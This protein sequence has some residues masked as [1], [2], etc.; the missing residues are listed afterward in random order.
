VKHKEGKQK[1]SPPPRKAKLP[2]VLRG[3]NITLLVP[4]RS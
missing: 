3:E 2:D 4:I 1:K